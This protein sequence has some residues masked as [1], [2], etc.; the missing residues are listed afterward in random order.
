MTPKSSLPNILIVRHGYI[1]VNVGTK[2]VWMMKGCG[3][4]SS[5]L[6]FIAFGAGLLLA[7]V[8][9]PQIILIL[10]AVALVLTGVSL[11]KN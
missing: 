8:C 4:F 5:G 10:A 3:N 11:V 7:T 6:L 1:R 2:A 9:P